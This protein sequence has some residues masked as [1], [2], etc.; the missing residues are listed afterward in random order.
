M[1][2]CNSVCLGQLQIVSKRERNTVFVCPLLESYRFSLARDRRVES[3][4]PLN[5]WVRKKLAIQVAHFE[6]KQRSLPRIV[7][8]G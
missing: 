1:G 6:C 2:P 8:S 5:G 3:F 4:R 7:Q